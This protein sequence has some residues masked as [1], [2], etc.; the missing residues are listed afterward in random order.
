MQDRA[1]DSHGTIAGIA[2]SPEFT[3]SS[4]LPPPTIHC[5]T[6]SAT[7]SSSF[8]KNDEIILGARSLSGDE[9]RARSPEEPVED[10]RYFSLLELLE[11]ERSYLESLRILVKVSSNPVC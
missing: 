1:R 6:K 7:E 8:T 9:G 5:S 11:T 10:S 4:L 2:Q 3:S